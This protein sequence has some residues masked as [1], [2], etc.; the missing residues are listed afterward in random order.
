MPRSPRIDL[1]NYYYHVINRAN[2]RMQIFD[3]NKDYQIFESLLEEAQALTDMF[4]IA[5]CVMPNHW[6]FVLSPK[7]AGDIAIFMKWL[8][9]THTRKWHVAHK[10]IGSGHIYQGRYK[11]FL[12]QE[13]K[14]L[15]Q[16]IRYVERNSL[17]AKL[18]KKSEDWKWSS[19]WRRE[20]GTKNNKELLAKWPIHMPHD[21][22]DWLNDKKEDEK[23]QKNIKESMTKG[24]PY[25]ND[26]WVM[27]AIENFGLQST[28][29]GSGR[30]KN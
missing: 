7:Q 17:K 4:I 28:V 30:P 12:I 24:K 20:K 18:V 13:D 3:T 26:G 21:Y 27:K 2:A 14:H 1:P 9:G 19:V 15:L 11:S 23:I 6:H 29:R 5:Y 22:L 25:G 10:S 8:T 16:V